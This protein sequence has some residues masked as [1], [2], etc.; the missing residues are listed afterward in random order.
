MKKD[1]SSY[2]KSDSKAPSYRSQNESQ[3]TFIKSN[4]ISNYEEDM[5]VLLSFEQANNS[6]F[7]KSHKSVTDSIVY[8]NTYS[9]STEYNFQ[10]YTDKI[11]DGL[12]QDDSRSYT[13]KGF[14]K[15]KS[16]ISDKSGIAQRDQSDSD[17]SGLEGVSNKS[18]ANGKFKKKLD[19]SNVKAGR[20]I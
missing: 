1:Q 4:N 7:I 8:T 9:V 17:S 10:P 6:T 15:Q 14:K 19:V 3:D 18:G 20:N 2:Q 13:S 12:D 5:S 11:L 16:V